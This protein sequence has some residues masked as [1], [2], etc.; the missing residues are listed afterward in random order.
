MIPL[1]ARQEKRHGHASEQDRSPAVRR[2]ARRASTVGPHRH[3]PG[4]RPQARRHPAEGRRRRPRRLAR[5]AHRR[6]P[7]HQPQHRLA[8]P[9]PVRRGGAGRHPAQEEGPRPPVPQAR[10]RA[11]GTADC[12]GLLEAPRGAGPLDHEAAGRQAGR[13]GGGRLRRSVHHLAGAS[14]NEIK[15]WLKQQWVIPP[16]G[17]AAFVANME[18]VLDVYARPY[19]EGHPVVCVDEGGKQLIGDVR[20]PLPV[21]PG[22]PAKRDYEYERRGMAN[23]FM[24]VEPLGGQRHVEVTAR[25]TAVDF[26]RFMKRVSDEWYPDARRVVPVCANLNTHTPACLY[27]AFEP[28]EARRL[29]ERFEWHHTPKHGSWLNVAGCE[30]SVVARQ[31]LDRRIPDLQT[32]TQEVAAWEEARNAAAVKVDWQFTTADARV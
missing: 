15:P 11:G 19:D 29:A 20:G 32:L 30:L 25:K 17:S 1:P 8:G 16:R 4:P 28:A 6:G 12:P 14:K 2:R 27:E 24:A 5:R 3:P 18:D 22:S 7:G 23:L 10:R 26:A 21:R 31:C 9:R 13:V